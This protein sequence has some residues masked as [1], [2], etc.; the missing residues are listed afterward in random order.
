[1][2]NI[3]CFA[4]N[5]VIS[6]LGILLSLA[7]VAGPLAASGTGIEQQAGGGATG[8]RIPEQGDA[9]RV[10]DQAGMFNFIMVLNMI[11]LRCDDETKP[12][13]DET[14]RFVCDKGPNKGQRPRIVLLGSRYMPLFFIC[15]Y[16][17]NVPPAGK[18]IRMSKPE[19]F[20]LNNVEFVSFSHTARLGVVVQVMPPILHENFHTRQALRVSAVAWSPNGHYLATGTGAAQQHEGDEQMCSL[21]V[22][23]IIGGAHSAAMTFSHSSLPRLP[24]SDIQANPSDSQN[25]DICFDDNDDCTGNNDDCAGNNKSKFQPHGYELI[26]RLAFP[27]TVSTIAFSPDSSKVVVGCNDHAMRVYRVIDTEEDRAKARR[28]EREIAADSDKKESKYDHRKLLEISNA[29]NSWVNCVAWSPDGTTIA[30][31]SFDNFV[32]VYRF[33]FET[34][35]TR[36]RYVAEEQW[37]FRDHKRLVESLAFSRETSETRLLVS[38]SADGFIRVF[39]LYEQSGDAQL[40]A[41]EKARTNGN[42][43]LLRNARGRRRLLHE[44][45]GHARTGVWCSEFS[46]DNSYFATGGNNGELTLWTNPLMVE[47]VPACTDA[48]LRSG[49]FAVV[50]PKPIRRFFHIRAQHREGD[51]LAVNALSISSQQGCRFIVTASSIAPSAEIHIWYIDAEAEISEEEK[52]K[53]KEVGELV[54][55]GL[56]SRRAELARY[57]GN[58]IACH[59]VVFAPPGVAFV[60]ESDEGARVFAVSDENGIYFF[61][62]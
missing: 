53:M 18:P 40:D 9:A 57:R 29:A 6:S 48:Q 24:S 19:K 60:D 43:Q 55:K 25:Y 35:G 58:S 44:I 23:R 22:Y 37:A 41:D 51:P 31:G 12:C 34:R 10:F 20:P 16:G 47:G 4:R 62:L 17:R 36:S 27:K 13:D 52:E 14:K 21:F 54:A 42:Q 32:R 50:C 15:L 7:L 26:F 30:S 59:H 33:K 28:F 39:R 5:K 1:M 49:E 45:E 61:R 38:T 2:V 56:R 8:A 11:T 46:P 3:K